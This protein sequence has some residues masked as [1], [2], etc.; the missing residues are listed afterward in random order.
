PNVLLHVCPRPRSWRAFPGS[1]LN[2]PRLESRGRT[3]ILKGEQPSHD[4]G[5]LRAMSS[6][7][8][9]WNRSRLERYVDQAPSPSVA[10]SVKTHLERCRDCLH[11]V[12]RLTR[13]GTLIKSAL[14]EPVDP[15]WTGFWSGIQA[16]ISREEPMPVRRDPWWMPFWKPVWGHPRLAMG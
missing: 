1:G 7:A 4:S 10:R 15:D 5:I 2:L 12:E 16:R 8:C 13:F 14:P 6:L 9:L 3:G 11:H